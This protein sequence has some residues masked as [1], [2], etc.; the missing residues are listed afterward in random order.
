MGC[1]GIMAFYFFGQHSRIVIVRRVL[2]SHPQ[3]KRLGLRG[4]IA[5]CRMPQK[6]KQP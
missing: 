2:L 4:K 3:A 6:N 5:I 1:G